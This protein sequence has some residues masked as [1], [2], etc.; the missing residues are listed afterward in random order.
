[1]KTY[2]NIYYKIY[3]WENLLLAFKKAR[4][5][6]TKKKDVKNFEKNLIENLQQL[7]FELMTQTYK[8]KPL[9]TFI[10]R[11]PK[12][13][14]ISKSDF[15]DRVT[16]HALCNIIEQIFNKIFI[17]DNCA[18]R[19]NKGTS[20]AI[21]KFE[22]FQLKTTSNLT[23]NG[24]CLKADIKH[25]FQEI[26]HKILLRI[27][28]KKIKCQK[29]IWLI[30]QILKG[31][32]KQI[33][34]GMPLGNLT[35]QFFASIYLN[36]LDYF[37]KHQL[38]EK[39]YVRYVDDFLILDPSKSKLIFLKDKIKKFLRNN[40]KL[41]LH[42][43]KSKIISLSKGIDF[44]GF[45]NHYHF[46]LLR[47]RSIRSMKRKIQLFHNNHITT[48]KILE[49][50]Q[51]WQAHA[52]SANTYNLRKH[53]TQ[54]LKPPLSIMLQVNKIN[55]ENQQE[56]GKKPWFLTNGR[57]PKIRTRN[58]TRRTRK[59]QRPTHRTNNSHGPSRSN[60]NPNNKTTRR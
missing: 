8:P 53:I 57:I 18:G 49:I 32:S 42:K 54:N 15:R 25:Y 21:K 55:Q 60:I 50:F 36:E 45:R 20:F 33:D 38:K 2:K 51:G 19:K 56:V 31:E 58:P 12:T 52:K 41:E 44:V 5:R 16:H 13:R 48:N 22:K 28:Q 4:R 7:Q 1:M 27:M 3:K 59:L 24:Y 37:I 35:S 40:L 46:K 47:Q 9:K 39:Y 14:K 23:S 30:K 6:K 10:L 17:Y 34:K 26:N 11:D 43:N 29:T